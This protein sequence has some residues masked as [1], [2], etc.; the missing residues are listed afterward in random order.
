MVDKHPALIVRCAGVADVIASIQ[1][2][3]KH[4]LTASVRGGGHNV[5]GICLCDGLVIDLSSMRSVH[6][7]PTARTVRVEGGPLGKMS[8]TNFSPSA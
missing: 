2:A 8:T 6:V 3:R 7:D 5:A 4:N 1:F